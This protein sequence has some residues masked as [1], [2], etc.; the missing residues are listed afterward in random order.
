MTIRD[1]LAN[2][3]A[4]FRGRAHLTQQAAAEL[5]GTKK[6]TVSSWE[7]GVSQPNADMLVSIALTY[8]VSLSELCGTDYNMMYTDEEN[9][10]IRA[11]RNAD[12]LDKS[13]VRRILGIREKK[14][15]CIQ[16]DA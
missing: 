8:K 4:L 6:T 14:D 15:N 9:D 1:V 16:K 10:L 11:F 2:N 13:M 5:L 12:D 7:R 3:L